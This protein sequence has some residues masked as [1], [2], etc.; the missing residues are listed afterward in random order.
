VNVIAH[1]NN[2]SI[3]SN[4]T[5]SKVGHLLTDVR[6]ASLPILDEPR[7]ECA[8]RAA[9]GG[10]PLGSKIEAWRSRNS[11]ATWRSAWELSRQRQQE[12]A[13]VDLPNA[14][15][16]PGMSHDIVTEGEGHV[17]MP[18]KRSTTSGS[19]GVRDAAWRDAVV[20]GGDVP[21]GL[22]LERA[23]AAPDAA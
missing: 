12:T 9:C 2:T 7:G 10:A 13:V 20:D 18:T 11:A 5:R 14:E 6:R 21:A 22:Q 17:L 8:N 3:G 4:W 23:A 19:Y 1:L 16:T 15:G